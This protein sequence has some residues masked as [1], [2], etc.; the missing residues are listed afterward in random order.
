MTRLVIINGVQEGRV[1]RLRSGINRIGRSL[2]NHLQVPDPSVSGAHCE[3]IFSDSEILVRDLQ[4]TNGTLIDGEPIQEGRI[5]IGQLLQLGNVQMRLDAPALTSEE[6]GVTVPEIAPP[7]GPASTVL[8]DGSFSCANHTEVRAEYRCTVC[9]QAF[10]GACVRI[11][12]RV[13]SKGIMAFC[14]LCAGPCDIL[15]PPAAA[16]PPPSAAQTFFDRL[17]ETL[18]LPFRKRRE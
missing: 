13:S 12:R 17:S 7:S 16:T 9:Q 18:K 6:A 11:I 5:H 4:S 15:A 2:E 10:C 1:L 14:P 8:A 3:V